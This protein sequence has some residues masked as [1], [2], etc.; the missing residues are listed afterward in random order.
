MGIPFGPDDDAP[1]WHR[2]WR[3]STLLDI[4]GGAIALRARPRT[5][6]GRDGFAPGLHR[7]G[8]AFPGGGCQFCVLIQSATATATSFA[9][10]LI[11][12][13]TL[14]ASMRLTG[15]EAVK[16]WR[17]NSSPSGLASVAS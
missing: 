7:K 16:R 1:S 15:T 8:G 17:I 9:A 2:R 13:A 12:G 14:F 4:N 11:A 3:V 6:L 10:W 5:C